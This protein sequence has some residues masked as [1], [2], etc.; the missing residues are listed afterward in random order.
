MIKEA[1]KYDIFSIG[2]EAY[3]MQEDIR[4]AAKTIAA[5]KEMLDNTEPGFDR[6]DYVKEMADWCDGLEPDE[7]KK[8]RFDWGILL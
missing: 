5:L 2:A 7:S 4:K 6:E 3:G 8:T 1:K